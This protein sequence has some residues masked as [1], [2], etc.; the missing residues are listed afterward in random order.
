MS[1][2]KSSAKK[3]AAKESLI[4]HTFLLTAA[5]NRELLVLAT[6]MNCQDIPELFSKIIELG[7]M[8]GKILGSG[9]EMYVIDPKE[10]KLV[11]NPKD[12]RVLMLLNSKLDYTNVSEHLAEALNLDRKIKKSNVFRLPVDAGEA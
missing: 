3:P 7:R 6:Q 1:N 2:K 11:E 5:Q 12:G 8:Y 4:Q 9:L 10:S